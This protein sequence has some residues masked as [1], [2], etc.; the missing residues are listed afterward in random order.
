MNKNYLWIIF[1]C[2]TFSAY[3]QRDKADKLYNRLEY[4]A[5][6][7][8]YNKAAT[9]T[10]E[11][12]LLLRLA[13]C[14]YKIN[15]MAMSE[16]WY[17]NALKMEE[18]KN[19]NDYFQY[20]KA[21][22]SN[23][24]FEDAKEIFSAYLKLKPEDA[25]GKMLYRSCD[26][27][28][29]WPK[30]T[31]EFQ[32]KRVAGINS[33]ES[34]FCPVYYRKSL[35]FTSS[36]RTNFLDQSVSGWTGKS[37]QD[38][39]LADI[40]QT[41][42]KSGEIHPFSDIIN[43]AGHDGPACFSADG[44]IIYF[45]RVSEAFEKSTKA[46]DQ[47]I[48]R[49]KIYTSTLENEKWTKPISFIYNSDDYSIG[50]PSLSSDG[51]KLFFASD[52]ADGLGGTDI[53]YCEW[54]DGTWS[55]PTNAG[56]EVNT[57]GNEKFPYIHND[58]T[59]YF[60]SDGRTG[61]GGLDIFSSTE[62]NGTF[63]Q[64]KN[65]KYPINSSMDDFGIIFSED[66]STAYLSSNRKGGLGEDDIYLII[67]N[68]KPEAVIATSNNIEKPIEITKTD[69]IVQKPAEQIIVQSKQDS[70]PI[71][72]QSVDQNKD[73]TLKFSFRS[74]TYVPVTE[75]TEP[76]PTEQAVK[77]EELQKEIPSEIKPAEVKEKEV[78]QIA[79]VNIPK[80][81][82]NPIEKTAE[83]IMEKP[84]EKIAE[85]PIEK[86]VEKIAEK[87]IEKPIEK[88]IEKPIEKAVEKIAEKPLEKPIEKI[89]ERPIEKAIEKPIAR[90]IEKV[91]E[92]EV[93]T[94]KYYSV[95]I[96]RYNASRPPDSFPDLN[97]VLMTHEA[98]LYIYHIGKFENYETAKSA[99]IQLKD[100]LVP[101][102]FVTAYI[103]GKKVALSMMNE[104]IKYIP[105]PEKIK[106]VEKIPEPIAIQTNEKTVQKT[107][108]NIAKSN[109]TKNE[110]PECYLTVQVG[111]F[112]K[113][114][115]Q[116]LFKNIPG[117]I[118]INSNTFYIYSI[119]KYKEYTEAFSASQKIKEQGFP[120][121]F[122]TARID[123]ANVKIEDFV[124]ASTSGTCICNIKP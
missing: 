6:I 65:L 28:K 14:Y 64:A 54:Q 92:Q 18:F 112:S 82:E 84:I 70:V 88:I 17:R 67:N 44:K 68:S 90:T 123:G 32:V 27:I 23:E 77:P 86:A 45:T 81:Q 95:Q 24:R 79:Q 25:V 20:G 118:M 55:K 102:A 21:L 41:E 104:K 50:H 15:D 22:K 29:N 116:S 26:I 115:D 37:Y 71:A 36:R 100:H 108:E 73:T 12:D 48:S 85:K 109:Q 43:S 1:L 76:N 16:Y 58:G 74:T 9:K 47:M 96:G 13:D 56:P 83:P 89:A 8:F 80:V 46:N 59:L 99:C 30:D 3:A 120:D 97:N 2:C 33:E 63:I 114:K 72:N 52:M 121:A 49:L 61:Y 113:E 117:L 66:Q 124:N 93:V 7:P 62:K 10:A 38:I 40:N 60:S 51:K 5:A 105:A 31:S 69:S 94:E 107:P 122:I 110:L 106:P 39:F 98:D 57:A 42:N 87:P 19:P 75:K 34:D 4:A 101:D 53:Y 11:P 119:G 78:E 111:K 103:N 91:Q 35:V